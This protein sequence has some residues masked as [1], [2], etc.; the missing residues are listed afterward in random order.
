MPTGQRLRRRPST[1]SSHGKGRSGRNAWDPDTLQPV[2]RFPARGQGGGG[3]RIPTLSADVALL[4]APQRLSRCGEQSRD[5]WNRVEL[6]L[7][8]RPFL[9]DRSAPWAGAMRINL[10]IS[11][12]LRTGRSVTFRRT[13][14]GNIDV[15]PIDIARRA[16][17]PVHIRCR[18]GRRG[19]SGR[20][21][22]EPHQHFRQIEK[23][24][25]TWYAKPSRRTR[26]GSRLPLE[27]PRAEETSSTGS[28]RRPLHRTRCSEREDRPEDIWGSATLWRPG[29]VGRGDDGISGS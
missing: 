17:S 28:F 19:R 12:W 25:S 23:A 5:G 24:S 11:N 2:R 7:L 15:W 26:G 21:N 13:V 27:I 9:A 22:G 1:C 8:V 20:P 6:N 18:E 10:R 4:P 3:R 29:T 14:S 16:A